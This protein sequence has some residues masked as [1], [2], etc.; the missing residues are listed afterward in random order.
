MDAFEFCKEFGRMCASYKECSACALFNE[1]ISGNCSAITNISDGRLKKKIE[2]VEKWSKEHPPKTMAQDFSRSFRRHQSV[3]T[4]LRQLAY[5]NADIVRDR[6]IWIQTAMTA[7]TDLWR[8]NNGFY[9]RFPGS[10]SHRH[11]TF[12]LLFEK[13]WE[14]V[15][16]SRSRFR[17]GVCSNGIAVPGDNHLLPT[18]IDF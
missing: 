3:R 9:N 17:S 12:V 4:E 15:C 14:R 13:D 7:G 11:R 10:V 2:V 1:T 5:K 16:K 6:A 18:G 8:N